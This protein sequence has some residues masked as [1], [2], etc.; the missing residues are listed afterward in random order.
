MNP[1]NLYATALLTAFLSVC[2]GVGFG[3]NAVLNDNVPSTHEQPGIMQEPALGA[4][5]AVAGIR[6]FLHGSGV[7]ATD[8]SITLTSF[9]QPVNAYP[10]Q[11]ADFGD[12]GY[13]TLEPGNTTRQEFISFTGI[14]Q[15]GDGTATLTGVT[16]GLSPVT[17][18]TAS[19]TIRK[20]HPGG[21][22][23][24]ISNPPQFYER[25]ANKLNTQDITAIWT[26]AS[27]SWPKIDVSTADPSND[28][29]F[30]TKKYVDDTAFSGASVVDASATARGVSE[31]ATGCEAASSTA[32]GGSGILVIPS[33]LATSTRNSAT[34]PCRIVSTSNDGYVD[35]GFM[36]PIYRTPV[37]SVTAFS[38][39]TAPSGWLLADGSAVS[40]TT[41]AELY[42]LLGT[43]YGAGNGATTFNLPNLTGR[44]IVMA[45]STQTATSTT[46]GTASTRST[47][48]YKGG[49]TMH[50]QTENEMR[51]HTHTDALS[52]GS[53]PN[54][55][56]GSPF[57]TISDGTTG[58]TG[59]SVPFNVLDPYIILNYIIK[60]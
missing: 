51:A 27:T 6:Y 13:L 14:T 35:I 17:P 54:Q 45:S 4:V 41:Y 22:D 9:K 43:S 21:S 52:E 16:R 59:N 12:I 15:N 53:G 32:S 11:M 33:S 49:E 38:S 58:S 26:F 47:L 55:G 46:D 2:A 57:A 50:T 56:T 36:N 18:Y 1:I 60:Y 25:F 8:T 20:A 5:N 24:V 30:A 31:L 48:G 44:S 40:R 3:L 10:L 39:T 34:S 37:G 7:G 29:E 23:A 42:T 28:G 19:S